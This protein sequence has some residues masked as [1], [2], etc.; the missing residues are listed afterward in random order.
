MS[1]TRGRSADQSA[2]V[3]R[4]NKSVR[5]RAETVRTTGYAALEAARGS[6]IV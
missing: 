1:T 6:F 3:R 5:D 4:L 2:A